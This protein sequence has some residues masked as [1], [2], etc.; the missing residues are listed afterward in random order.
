V[1]DA[2]P[3]R[4]I[5]VKAIAAAVL[6]LLFPF[7]TAVAAE[8]DAKRAK[9][10]ITMEGTGFNPDT[11]EVRTGDTIVWMNN[12]PFPHTATSTTQVFDSHEIA[13]GQSWSFTPTKTGT[14]PYV[15]AY[16]PT[17]KGVIRVSEGKR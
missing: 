4:R 10:T 8:G 5:A 13:A 6:G 7:R 16:H 9:R 11:L 14:F 1:A 12:D 2:D 17:M 15:C 3:R